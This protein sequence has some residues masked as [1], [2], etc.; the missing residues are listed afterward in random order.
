MIPILVA[1]INLI[2][3]LITIILLF[4]NLFIK[5]YKWITICSIW[6]CYAC[7][8]IIVNSSYSIIFI[9]IALFKIF[10]LYKEFLTNE[11]LN[12]K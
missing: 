2:V 8:G 6:G 7:A 10:R 9:I 11:K 4:L 1:L 12:N 3:I 5:K